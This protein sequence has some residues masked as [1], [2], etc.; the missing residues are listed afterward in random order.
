[1]IPVSAPLIGEEEL[2]NV[3]D[4]IKRGEISGTVKDDY[5]EKFESCVCQQCGKKYGVATTSGTTA[6]ALAVASL[7]IKSGDEVIVP[8]FTNIATA[9]AA[10][11]VGAKPVF[12]D[13]EALTWNIDPNKIEEKITSATKAIIPVHIYGHPADMDSIMK[14]AKK[15]N[16]YV[17]ED[18]AEAQGATYK[19]KAVGGIGHI[20][21]FSFYA[22][23]LITTGEGGM[24]VTDDIDIAEKARLLRN[25][26]FSSREKFLHKY[27]GYNFRMTNLQAAIGVAQMK[28]LETHCNMKRQIAQKYHDRLSKVP[29]LQL[30][31]EMAWAKNVYWMYGVVLRQE[32]PTRDD[33]RTKLEAKGIETRNFFRP[34]HRQPAF[35]D[36]GISSK[37]DSLPVSE[38]L[39]QRGFY[40]PS[41]PALSDTQI[42]F[43]C[44]ALKECLD[45]N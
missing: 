1:M 13:S 23:K 10:V 24:V 12:V 11:Y 41:G 21:C 6:L 38:L 27:I 37:E 9:F 45:V 32:T 19:D 15:H 25:L 36:L 14:M 33:I 8:A 35:L 2:E 16:I 5:I 39:G 22:N 3:V 31:V 40:L 7:N 44:D 18:A 4:C 42:D 43:I 28:R 26:A 17:I 29:K 20:G 30:P 34:L